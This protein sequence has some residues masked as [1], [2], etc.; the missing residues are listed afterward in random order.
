LALTLLFEGHVSDIHLNDFDRSIWAFWDSALNATDDLISLIETAPID[1]EG[2]YRQRDI[3][4]NASDYDDLTLG[5]ATFFLNRTNRSG[6]VKGAGVIGGLEQ[7]GNYKMDC[8]FNRTGLAKRIKR[9]AKYRSRIHLHQLDA[10]A[11]MDRMDESL[12]RNYPE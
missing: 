8:R 10:L 5:F 2:W 12:I 3:Y 7:Q 1:M 9:I 6:I 11:F 4:Q